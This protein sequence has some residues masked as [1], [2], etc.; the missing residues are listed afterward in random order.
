LIFVVVAFRNVKLD[1]VAMAL[2]Q[3]NYAYLLPALVAYFAGVWVRSLRWSYLLQPIKGLSAGRLFPVVVIGYMANDVLPARLGELVR[4][5]VL[6]EKERV[7][8]T[9]TLATIVV[10]RL[11][12]GLVM[13]VFMAVA[14]ALVPP[15]KSTA[16]DLLITALRV[17]SVIFV[18]S[19]FVFLAIAS[20]HSLAL[21]AIARVGRFL[22]ARVGTPIGRLSISFLSGLTIL[23]DWRGAMAVFSLTILAWLC[24][25]VMYYIIMLGFPFAVSFVVLV[26]TTALANLW[27]I[28]PST[29]GYVGTFDAPVI[30]VLVL[31]GVDQSVAASYTIVL[32]AAL[33]IPVVLLGAVFLFRE[34][35]SLGRMSQPPGN[36]PQ[37]TPP[38]A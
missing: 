4:A 2:T 15:V 8:K 22:P 31:Y 6:G 30:L 18:G 25:A 27:T 20:S 26:L 7:S 35:L 34:G 12:D 10:E 38:L 16:S 32:H 23:R 19:L 14:L 37:E 33:I 11:F 28:V 5:Y 21:Q 1:E 36:L 3:A 29:P 24:E 13:L 17:G 9:G